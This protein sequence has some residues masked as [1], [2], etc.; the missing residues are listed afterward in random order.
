ME[1]KRE[2]MKEEMNTKR[3]DLEILDGR[4]DGRAYQPT[5]HT[6]SGKGSSGPSRNKRRMRGREG[7]SP[8]W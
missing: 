3:L 1:E 4:T 7:R 6:M 5:N 2:G 8:Q